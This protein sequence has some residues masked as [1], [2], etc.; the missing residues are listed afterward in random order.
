LSEEERAALV[1][2][3]AVRIDQALPAAERAAR[4]A[5]QIKTPD[6]FLC[7]GVVVRLRFDPQGGDLK[8]HLLRYWI[9][10]AQG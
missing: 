9:G 2:I 6:C 1:D 8:S 3:D 10:R 5:A 4:Y 7:Q